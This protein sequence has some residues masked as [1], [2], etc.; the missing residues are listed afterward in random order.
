MTFYGRDYDHDGQPIPD[1]PYAETDPDDDPYTPTWGTVDLATYAN[2]DYDPP[3]ATLMPRDDGVCLLYPGLTH[4]IHG[5][6]ESGKSWIAQAEA[7]R[8]LRDGGHV[9]YVDFESDPASI[10]GRFFELGITPDELAGLDYRRPEVKPTHD[11]EAG[12][13]LEMLGHTYDLAIIDGVT[14]SL[15]MWGFKL[16]DNDDVATWARQFPKKLAAL[17]G[18]AVVMIDHVTKNA[19][20]RGRFAIGGQ[21][22]MSGL[23]GAAYIVDVI[24]PLGRG[25]CGVLSLRVAKDRPGTVRGHSGEMRKTDRTQEVARFV[26]NA[27]GDKLGAS[28]RVPE[29]VTP[30]FRPTILMGRV[31]EY[32]ALYPASSGRAIA[33]GVTG[34]VKHIRQATTCL[35]SEGFVLTERRGTSV[36]HT[37]RKPF[38]DES[39]RP[40]SHR[41][42]TAS[43]DA[44]DGARPASPPPKGGRAPATPKHN[45]KPPKIGDAV[46]C[47]PC[48]CPN[49]TWGEH[50]DP[51][52]PLDQGRTA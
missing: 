47:V 16:T 9:L 12:A 40:A 11:G 5:E 49:G 3:T 48:T 8:I 35:V 39:P 45:Q 13:W 14:D 29:D 7:A 20:T 4:S 43:Q 18:A 44:L 31:S 30:Q 28:L 33:E 22:K 46:N 34:K 17:T 24:D 2:G 32:L 38:T 25:L 21:A 23:T 19:D 1:D 15:G 27:T 26:L 36:L 41:V 6:S 37:N 52:I 42:P 10:V 51:C 50:R